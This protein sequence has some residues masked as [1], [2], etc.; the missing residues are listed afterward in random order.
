MFHNIS[1]QTKLIIANG[2]VILLFILALWSALSGTFSAANES[3]KFFN[4][5]LARQTAYQTM[6]ADGL[7]SGVALRNL[8][9]K[10]KA[11]KPFKVVPAAI[12][13]FDDA[14]K[15]V[16]SMPSDDE[17]L[18]ASFDLID[19]HWQKSRSAKFRVLELVKSGDVEEAITV[20][21]KEEHPNWQK[22]RVTVQKLTNKELVEN[23]KIQ[24]NILTRTNSTLTSTLIIALIAILASMF[25][26]FIVIRGIKNAFATV[27]NSL[28][29]IASGEGDLTRRLNE[30]GEKEVR[31]LSIAFNLFVSK[32]QN[33]ISEVSSSSA[34][35][36]VAIKQLTELSV[37]TKLNVN[38]QE[39]K[40]EQVATAM[41]QMTATVQ[42]VA[43]NAGNAS[44]SARAADSESSNG[45]KVVADVISSINNLATDVGNT[46]TTINALKE[47]TEQIGS[48]LDVIKGIAE[49]TNLLAL[50]AAIEAA[51]AGEQGRGFAVVADEVRTLASRTQEAT[52]EI[53]EMIERLQVGAKDAVEAMDSGQEKTHSTVEK[54]ELAGKALTAI[55]QAVSNIAEQN[56]HIATAAEEQSAVAEE[57][58]QNIVSVSTLA[59]QAAQGAEHTAASSQEL[60]ATAHKL[61]E[62]ISMFKV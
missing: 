18:K 53:Q 34:H 57:I 61:Q 6:F 15:Y 28:N 27:T 39:S 35:L 54:A 16:R 56:T 10:P 23:K 5:N 58:N 52:Q 8:V 19:A 7:L 24:Q 36:I 22:V 12:K 4:E 20:L 44:D 37:D 47:D 3:D 2:L 26:S 14:F 46:S 59:V 45:Q 60:E 43:R 13:R 40:I 41:N 55:T 9:L 38:Q 21:K 51:R 30:N 42:E 11:K 48:V 33:L 29:D 50:N 25:I 62:M 1:I 49:Q 31:G 17:S 32:I